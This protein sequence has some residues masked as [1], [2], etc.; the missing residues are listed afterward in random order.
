MQIERRQGDAQISHLFVFTFKPPPA[1]LKST[2]EMQ[3][4]CKAMKKVDCE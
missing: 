3:G 1:L 2:S 4:K